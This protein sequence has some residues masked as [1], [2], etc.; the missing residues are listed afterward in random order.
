MPS[1]HNLSLTQFSEV[2]TPLIS[3]LLE[4]A[5]RATILSAIEN[6]QKSSGPGKNKLFLTMVGGGVFRNPPELI[7][8]ALFKQKDLILNSGVL[9]LFRVNLS[10][11]RSQ[12]GLVHGFIFLQNVVA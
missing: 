12:F 7:A 6:S 4:G 1:S 10:R 11:I 8:E 5:Y 2:F 3:C 9:S